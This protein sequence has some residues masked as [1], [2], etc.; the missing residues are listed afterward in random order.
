MI[1]RAL[2]A[3]NHR[4]ML[5]L[6]ACAVSTLLGCAGRESAGRADSATAAAA[7]RTSAGTAATNPQVAP[8]ATTSPD[9]LRATQPAAGREPQ[10]VGGVAA[11]SRVVKAGGLD[12]TSVGY[13]RGNPDAPVVVVEFSDFGCPYC[14]KFARE[15]YPII[16]REYIRT[17]KVFFKSVQFVMG[18]FPNATEAARAA[19]CAADQRQF[20]PMSKRLYD[21]QPEWK[22]TSSPAGVLVHDAAAIGLDT[23]RFAACY[24]AGGMHPRTRLA[25]NAASLL[26]VRATPSFLVNGRP[27]EGALPIEAFR[28]VLDDA[29]A[30]PA[31][32]PGMR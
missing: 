18:S 4:R 27:I 29:V 17:G 3:V 22:G 5:L 30:H 20:W 9:T 23:A 6:T 13:D 8:P 10:Q 14:G 25:T 1:A 32:T 19:E 2:Q 15:T 31:G 7:L 16:D 12:L 11:D 21:T 24:G 28:T 26:G